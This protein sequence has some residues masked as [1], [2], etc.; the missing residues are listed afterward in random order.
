MASD[1]ARAHALLSLPLCAD[2]FRAYSVPSALKVVQ[3]S[4]RRSGSAPSA[5]LIGRWSAIRR[6]PR[7]AS[8]GSVSFT[9][10][11]DSDVLIFFAC[12]L[13]CQHSL[14]ASRPTETCS[15][16][17]Q[18]TELDPASSSRLPL[19]PQS[20]LHFLNIR[21]RCSI[22]CP[23]RTASSLFATFSIAG[24]ARPHGFIV[25]VLARFFLFFSTKC[26][27]F[28]NA[29]QQK[30][31]LRAGI[32]HP[33]TAQM[34]LAK[35]CYDVR[36]VE[37]IY[38]R[39]Y[40]RIIWTEGLISD[41]ASAALLCSPT[42]SLELRLLTD[43]ASAAADSRLRYCACCCWFHPLHLWPLLPPVLCSP[44]VGVCLTAAAGYGGDHCQSTAA[45]SRSSHSNRAVT[46]VLDR[47]AFDLQSIRHD[48][49]AYLGRSDAPAGAAGCSDQS[50][51]TFESPMAHK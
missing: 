9:H 48:S 49:S 17:R 4:T 29:I 43:G 41:L 18:P 51:S 2:V 28:W 21:Y 47:R 33:F 24:C 36:R 32:W 45:S 26:T 3:A 46:S 13:F 34:Y 20:V 35:V 38:C 16:H 19:S 31:N 1:V 42:Q 5:A 8:L 11:L 12:S 14:S 37:V 25:A 6:Q 30:L 27:D 7:G 10:S 39:C 44:L 22:R 50:T 40:L 15:P 23:V